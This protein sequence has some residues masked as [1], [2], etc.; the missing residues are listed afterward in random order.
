MVAEAAAAAA[1]AAKAADEDDSAEA[2]EG[3]EAEEAAPKA[4]GRPLLL[5]RTPNAAGR[6][7]S[8]ALWGGSCRDTICAM[9][10]DEE[11]EE[12]EEVAAAEVMDADVGTCGGTKGKFTERPSKE[13]SSSYRRAASSSLLGLGLGLVLVLTLVLRLVLALLLLL[14]LLLLTFFFLRKKMNVLVF[15]RERDERWRIAKD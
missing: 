15:L 6:V 13:A 8:K 11:E 5:G 14:L 3:E 1:A 4:A 12:E 7:P 9:V 10:L 2:A